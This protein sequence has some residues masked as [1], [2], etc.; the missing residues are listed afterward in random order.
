MLGLLDAWMN[1]YL[2]CIFAD[3]VRI[4]DSPIILSLFS[5]ALANAFLFTEGKT[6]FET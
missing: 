2:I 4:R 3:S 1:P 6:S 5:R